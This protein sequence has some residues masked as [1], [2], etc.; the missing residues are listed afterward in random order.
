MGGE[1]TKVKKAVVLLS[2][3]LDSTIT[4][5]LAKEKGLELYAL[6]VRYGQRHEQEVV[7]ARKIAEELGVADHKIV[8]LN[9]AL[10][11]GSALTDGESKMPEQRSPEEIEEGGIPDTYVPARNAIMLSI[12]L[13]YAETVNADEIYIG[14]HC[15]DYSGYPDCRPEFIKAYQAMADLATKRAIEG[16]PI[17]IQVP[18]IQLDKKQIIEKGRE[19]GVPFELTRS[20]YREGAKSCGTC[21]SCVL[22]KKGFTEAGIKDPVEYDRNL[23]DRI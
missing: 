22:R 8:E 9:L 20:C 10:F 5:Y 1:N 13:A 18:L 4:A 16:R 17:K 7:S 3:G 11:G 15:L 6:T 21:D 12:A 2:G 14:A 19:L 23:G